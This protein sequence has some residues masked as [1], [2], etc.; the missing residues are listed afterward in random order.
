MECCEKVLQQ[1]CD[2]LA[3]D[4]NSELCAQLKQHLQDC[5]D[6]RMQLQSMRSVV[7]LFQCLKEKDVPPDIHQ[8]LVKLLN[9]EESN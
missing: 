1:L 2:D 3:E 6:C 9:V 7:K 5:E 4:I 8:R